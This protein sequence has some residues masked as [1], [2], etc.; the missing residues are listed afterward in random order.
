MD[1]P[2]LQVLLAPREKPVLLDQLV[3]RAF[4]VFK[5]SKATLDRLVLKVT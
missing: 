5:E 1:R 2:A 4:R 3:R